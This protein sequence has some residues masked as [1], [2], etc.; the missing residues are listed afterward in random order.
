[1]EAVDGPVTSDRVISYRGFNC[2]ANGQ[3]IQVLMPLMVSY[4]PFGS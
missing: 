4:F 2:K 3:F 1:V